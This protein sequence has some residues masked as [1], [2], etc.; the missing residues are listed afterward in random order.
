M[1]VGSCYI[2]KEEIEKITLSFLDPEDKRQVG[3]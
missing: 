3:P 1:A 2:Q